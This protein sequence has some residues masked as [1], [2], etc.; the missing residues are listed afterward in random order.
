M[1]AHVLSLLRFTL[2]PPRNGA[3]CASARRSPS[4]RRCE[5]EGTAHRAHCEARR[6][7]LEAGF[8]TLLRLRAEALA[9]D[10][11]ALRQRRDAAQSNGRTPACTVA[12]P[13]RSRIA[14]PRAAARRRSRAS[15]PSTASLPG[16]GRACPTSRALL[17]ATRAH[18]GAA[19]PVEVRIKLR[20]DRVEIGE[21]RGA[22]AFATAS[23]TE[24]H[25]FPA[26]TARG[27]HAPTRCAPG[28]MHS[29]VLED[30]AIRLAALDSRFAQ[31]RQP[32]IA[33]LPLRKNRD[34]VR[35]PPVRRIAL[36]AAAPWQSAAGREWGR[37]RRAPRDDCVVQRALVRRR[38]RACRTQWARAA[39]SKSNA[40][41]GGGRRRAAAGRAAWRAAYA[42]AAER[43]REPRR[44]VVRGLRAGAQRSVRTPS[45]VVLERAEL[46]PHHALSR[47]VRPTL[48]LLRR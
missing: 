36:Q 32:C 8:A 13:R 22:A 11:F 24:R 10:V 39:R 25:R 4:L 26:R 35:G 34:R 42:S 2:R 9:A 31:L 30:R 14:A 5:L 18:P 48:Q 28:R 3:E 45:C 44:S 38:R 43:G 23:A 46:A 1:R 17:P 37:R 40:G 47:A 29:A 15:P 12:P 16:P 41:R 19:Q 20:P 7:D 21:L 6:T 33:P 27:R